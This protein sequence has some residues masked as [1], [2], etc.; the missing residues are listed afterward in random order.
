MPRDRL[1]ASHS[2][3]LLLTDPCLLDGMGQFVGLWARMH[4]QFILPIGVDKIE[5]YGPPPPVGTTCPLRM[6]VVSCDPQTRQMRF[7]IE[8][9]DGTGAVYARFQGWTDWILNCSVRYE[10]AA[11]RPEC[12]VLSEEIALPGLTEG[13]VGTLVTR[14][15][16]SGADPEWAARLFLHSQEMPRFWEAS[17]KDRRRQ[18]LASRAAV[19]DAVRLWWSRKYGTA[20]PHPAE[21]AIEHDERG[22]PFLLPGDDPALPHISLAHTAAAAVAIASDVPVGIDVEEADRDTH[23]ILDEFTTAEER[24]LIDPLS[25]KYP[26][27][28]FETRLWCAKEAAAKALGT[29]LGGR[30]RDF[31][32]IEIEEEGNF[33]IHHASTRERLVVRSARFGA[34]LVAWTECRTPGVSGQAAAQARQRVTLIEGQD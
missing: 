16:L 4:Q 29:G 21:F 14:D 23:S 18:F 17:G 15:Y 12:H 13:S 7:H 9:E 5:F 26:E 28:N 24:A 11:S 19:K 8:L 32:A 3:P 30:P 33:L 31:E 25:T 20:L 27:E 6:E 10:E 1:F 34:F 22:R 2:D